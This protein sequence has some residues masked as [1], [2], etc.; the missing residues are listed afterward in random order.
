MSMFNATERKIF[1]DLSAAVE[2]YSK[3]FLATHLPGAL[4]PPSVTI[5]GTPAGTSG[6]TVSLS[7]AIQTDDSGLYDAISYKWSAT[8]GTF[9]DTT[10]SSPTYTRPTVSQD[11]NVTV[12]CEVTYYGTDGVAARGTQQTAEV[13]AAGLVTA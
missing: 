11:T 3:A 2:R 4:K 8:A 5:I 12:T 13:R 9:S 6:S 1:S 10:A 7:I